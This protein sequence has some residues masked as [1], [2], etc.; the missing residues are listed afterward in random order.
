MNGVATYDFTS[1][2]G[3]I[4]LVRGSTNHAGDIL[5]LVIFDVPAFCEVREGCFIWRSGHFYVS[6]ILYLS[7]VS[8]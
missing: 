8:T 5:D 2:S 4:Q 6:F 3:C 1:S 7:H